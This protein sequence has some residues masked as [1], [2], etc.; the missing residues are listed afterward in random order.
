MVVIHRYHLKKETS[1]QECIF[2]P[3]VCVFIASLLVFKQDHFIATMRQV[4][5]A[6]KRAA[7]AAKLA[8]PQVQLVKQLFRSHG[9]LTVFSSPFYI[10]LPWWF[11]KSIFSMLD[12]MVLQFLLVKKVACFAG[13]FFIIFDRFTMTITLFFS[14]KKGWFKNMIWLISPWL[15]KK[16][17][18][19]V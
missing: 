12:M 1:W 17:A 19:D 6:S 4:G 9:F 15:P 14:N 18:P 8:A 7:Q 13:L 5:R 2:P 16:I 11:F 10:M 3:G